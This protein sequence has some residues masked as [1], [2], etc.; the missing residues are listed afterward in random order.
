MRVTK[1]DLEGAVAMLNRVTAGGYNIGHAYGQ[2]RLERNGGAFDISP[3]LPS[4][5]LLRWIRA[6]T[7]GYTSKE[8]ERLEAS[9]GGGS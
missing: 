6:Y 7:A 5:E 2:P 1:K 8:R 4:G 3:R 9:K